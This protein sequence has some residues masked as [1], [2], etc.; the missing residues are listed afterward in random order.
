MYSSIPKNTCP[1][2]HRSDD[3]NFFTGGYITTTADTDKSLDL[4]K[5]VY[6]TR[7]NFDEKTFS[8]RVDLHS[9]YIDIPL[10]ISQLSEWFTKIGV[11]DVVEHQYETTLLNLEIPEQKELLNAMLIQCNS[12]LQEIERAERERAEREAE[13]EAAIDMGEYDIGQE[14]GMLNWLNEYC[15]CENC[16]E[17]QYDNEYCECENSELKCTLTPSTYDHVGE[18]VPSKEKC[19]YCYK[20]WC[21]KCG[22]GVS[23][24]LVKCCQ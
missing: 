2:K 18:C 20:Y 10:S 16:D 6:L 19:Q 12:R 23:N 3:L 21:G 15:E 11:E 22:N 13:R 17:V 4:P 14:K 7:G 8:L 9:K 24:Y 5:S 1:T